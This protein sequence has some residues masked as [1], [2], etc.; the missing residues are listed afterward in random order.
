MTTTGWDMIGAGAVPPNTT[1][2][3]LCRRSDSSE[4]AYRLLPGHL[5]L[6]EVRRHP[7]V[8]EMVRESGCPVNE[9]FLAVFFDGK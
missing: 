9:C 6:D 8:V 2:V 5:T 7:E 1:L 4:V 3:R